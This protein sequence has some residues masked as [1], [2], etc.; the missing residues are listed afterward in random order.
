MHSQ[1]ASPAARTL[2]LEL[3]AARH[4]LAYVLA[5]LPGLIIAVLLAI[6]AINQPPLPLLALFLVVGVS[7]GALSLAAVQSIVGTKLIADSEGIKLNKFLDEQRYTWDQVES[8][9]VLASTGTFGDDPFTE[10]NDRIGVGLFLRGLNRTRENEFDA[11]L[12]LCAG[13]KDHAAELVKIVEKLEGFKKRLSAPLARPIAKPTRQA[14]QRE[15][16]RSQ[17]ST[18]DMVAA[19]RTRAG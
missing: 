16:F 19:M 18:S 10:V 14:H 17:R 4:T 8:V 7:C 12:I 9:K 15:Q 1:P 5:G 13:T 11:D 3:P 2:E 6:A